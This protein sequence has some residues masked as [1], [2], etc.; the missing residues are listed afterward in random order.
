MTAR[1]VSC[2]WRGPAQVVCRAVL[3]SEVPTGGLYEQG[4]PPRVRAS[5]M[6]SLLRGFSLWAWRLAWFV[7][8]MLWRVIIQ[9]TLASRV[10]EVAH[11]DALVDVILACDRSSFRCP[12]AIRLET[13]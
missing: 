13:I 1:V 10:H 11:E 3:A 2:S 6:E 5:G 9:L 4:I 12:V 7:D 8:D